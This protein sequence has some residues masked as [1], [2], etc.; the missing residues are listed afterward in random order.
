[1][2]A[3]IPDWKSA[4][5][6]YSFIGYVVAIVVYTLPAILLYYF[7][8]HTNPYYWGWLL[9]AVLVLGLVG[10][11][12]NQPN[13]H[14][15]RR[16]A[17][18]LALTLVVAAFAVPALASPYCHGEGS[19]AASEAEFNAIAV[20]LIRGWEGNEPIA[21]LDTI[22]KPP[23][24]TACSGATQYNGRPIRP[25][26]VFTEKQCL[27]LLLHDI[28]RHRDGL[29]LFVTDE[30]KRKRFPLTRDA[31]FT[32]FAFNVG[33]Y[34][35]GGSTAMKRLNGGNVKGACDALTWWNRAGDRIVRG[36]VRRRSEER[37]YC[38]MEPNPAIS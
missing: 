12:I 23:I 35:A 26:E 25:H 13:S 33:V 27:D 8:T 2:S 20:P 34:A 14:K 18:V 32:S 30:T 6:S 15:W 7:D 38:L 3:F 21:Y 22:A 4:L 36:L 11:F 5:K 24:W 17:I 10:R 16:K 29:H 19:V 1:M 9:L 31:A 37:E 28:K